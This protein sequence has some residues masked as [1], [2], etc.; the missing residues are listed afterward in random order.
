M[1][2]GSHTINFLP[3]LAE[4]AKRDMSHASKFGSHER[5][6]K[7]FPWDMDGIR[8]CRLVRGANRDRNILKARE[9]AGEVRET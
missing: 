3:S 9:Y 8:L 5:I 2:L 1:A 6:G 4:Y 7:M